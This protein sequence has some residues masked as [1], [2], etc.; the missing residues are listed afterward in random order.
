MPQSALKGPLLNVLCGIFFTCYALPVAGRQLLRGS[1]DTRSPV[2]VSERY[3]VETRRG[4]RLTR[5]RTCLGRVREHRRAAHPVGNSRRIGAP[6]FLN[7]GGS[8]CAFCGSHVER[9][10]PRWR[11]PAA[12]PLPAD[13]HHALGGWIRGDVVRR[14]ELSF[15]SGPLI[16][17]ETP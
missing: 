17:Q 9:V 3:G 2:R 1:Y 15:T 12:R 4:Y 16:H 10:L 13:D 14:A 6:R 8:R 11:P 5:W 7:T